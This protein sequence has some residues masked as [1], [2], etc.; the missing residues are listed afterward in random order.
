MTGSSK[1]QQLLDDAVEFIVS[2]KLLEMI[3]KWYTPGSTNIAGWNFWTL[4][5]SMPFLVQTGD[6]PASQMLVYRG[7]P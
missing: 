5:E 4:N 3:L 1:L 6:F 2:A 7:L